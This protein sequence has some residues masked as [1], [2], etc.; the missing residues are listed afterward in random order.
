MSGVWR[1]R[2]LEGP[3]QT[4]LKRIEG[5][6]AFHGCIPITLT[7]LAPTVIAPLPYSPFPQSGTS[8]NLGT[9]F[10]K[11]FDTKFIDEAQQLQYVH[12]TSWGASTRLIGG[13]IMT[14]GDDKG[15]RLPPNIAPV[16]ARVPRTP[17]SWCS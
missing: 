8:H 14:H 9:N 15:L 13:I 4:G 1:G 16:Q 11:A 5:S 12:Q 2:A 3:F 10:A 6:R 7:A 17:C